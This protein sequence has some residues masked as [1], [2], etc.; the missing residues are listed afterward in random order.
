MQVT[1]NFNGAN[2]NA[3]TFVFTGTVNPTV[4]AG[5]LTGS[6]Y[7]NTTTGA[8]FELQ[9]VVSSNTWVQIGSIQS[10]VQTVFGRNGAVIAQFGDYSFSQISGAATPGQLPLLSQMSGVVTSTQLP[11][12]IVAGNINNVGREACA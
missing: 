10:P 9:V 3:P 12:P 8:V 2:P 4:T 7:I 1:A 11:F 5:L 6:L